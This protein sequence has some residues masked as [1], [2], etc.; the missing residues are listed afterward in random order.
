M[1][2]LIEDDALVLFQGDSITDAGRYYDDPLDMR[3]GYARSLADE[4]DAIHIPLDSL[5]A[6]ATSRQ[7][8]PYWS[9]DGVH[10]TIAGHGLIAAA[11]LEALSAL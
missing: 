2:P 11:W 7:P 10:P 4:F 5:F 1:G 8:P 3:S 6:Q 9:E